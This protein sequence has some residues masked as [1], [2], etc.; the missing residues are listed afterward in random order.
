MVMVNANGW[1]VEKVVRRFGDR[2][3]VAGLRISWH[4]Y[5]QADC[6]TT[7]EVAEYVDLSTLVP[8]APH[9]YAQA[10]VKAP[11]QSADELLDVLV[12]ATAQSRELARTRRPVDRSARPLRVVPDMRRLLERQAPRGGADSRSA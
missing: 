2:V 7:A 11:W 12:R 5:W 9:K 4:G 10:A 6:R 8:E 1:R 3:P